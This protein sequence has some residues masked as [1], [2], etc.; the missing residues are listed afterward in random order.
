LQVQLAAE[1]TEPDAES[2]AESLRASIRRSVKSK[3]RD[4]VV[5]FSEGDGRRDLTDRDLKALNTDRIGL[6]PPSP[7]P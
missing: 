1:L 5:R 6:D 3:I 4:R 7:Q 2:E